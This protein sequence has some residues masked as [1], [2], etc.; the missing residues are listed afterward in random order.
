[1]IPGLVDAVFLRRENR[2]AAKVLLNGQVLPCHVPNSGRLKE[3]LVEGSPARVLPFKGGGRTACGLVMVKNMEHWV[4]IDA[5]RANTVAQEAVLAGVVPGL[6]GVSDLRR[7][8]V[9]G[10]SRFDMSC[11]VAGQLHYIEVKCS[12]LQQDGIGMFPDAPTERGHKHLRELISLSREGT[13]CHVLFVLQHPA[14]QS[15]RPHWE[16]DP[17]FAD[18]LGEAV[19]SGVDVQALTCRVDENSVFAVG[20]AGITLCRN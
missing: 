14:S 13:A 7:E 8:V 5:H 9:W 10:N 19:A 11:T 17:L 3:L 15:F 18:L 6:V 2:F 20:T 4:V 1:M 16:T 12:T